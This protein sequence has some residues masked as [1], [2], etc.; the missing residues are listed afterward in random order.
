MHM[1]NNN[2]EVITLL[3]KNMYQANVV[4]NRILITA[5]TFVVSMLFGV[6]GLS[7][8][9]IETDYLLYVRNSGTTAYTTRAGYR[10]TV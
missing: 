8:G 10:R 3:A 2:R 9:K 6:F 5:I 1:K 7:V 4:R